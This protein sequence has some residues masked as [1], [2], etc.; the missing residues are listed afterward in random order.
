MSDTFVPTKPAADIIWAKEPGGDIDFNDK[1]SS[2]GSW[3]GTTKKG[4]TFLK[5]KCLCGRRGMLF[6][7]INDGW[8]LVKGDP[9]P[10]EDW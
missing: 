3:S 4:D 8:K 6:T 2:V 5:V 1:E 7:K 10:K 9:I